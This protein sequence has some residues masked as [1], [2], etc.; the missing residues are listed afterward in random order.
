MKVLVFFLSLLSVIVS[1]RPDGQSSVQEQFV[2]IDEVNKWDWKG[3]LDHGY[4]VPL[5]D[6]VSRCDWNK[7]PGHGFGGLV[8]KTRTDAK[9]KVTFIPNSND[10]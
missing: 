7:S 10:F 1:I 9:L 5:N 3:F 2:N 6:D 8:R 4:K